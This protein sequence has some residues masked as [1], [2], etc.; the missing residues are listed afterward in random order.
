MLVDVYICAPSKCSQN[1][2]FIIIGF[3]SSKVNNHFKAK[4]F[5]T[6]ITRKHD[7]EEVIGCVCS[8]M[9]LENL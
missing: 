7:Q 5:L 4:V 8:I 3:S 1:Q 6:L 2:L 9:Q